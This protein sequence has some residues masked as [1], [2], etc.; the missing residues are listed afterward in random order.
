MARRDQSP[1]G[2]V[3]SRC[4]AAPQA[5]L[6]DPCRLRPRRAGAVLGDA[7]AG[8]AH[9]VLGAPRCRRRI[10][11]GS[12]V[13]AAPGRAGHHRARRFH[14]RPRRRR[15]RG[16]DHDRV[17]RSDLLPA[18]TGAGRSR[19]AIRNPQSA[20][21]DSHHARRSWQH[22]E[23]P[24]PRQRRRRAGAPRLLLQPPCHM[25][26]VLI[27]LGVAVMV[28]SETATLL[29][30]E[31]FWSW[32]TPIAWTGFILFADGVVYRARGDSWIRS[33]PHEFAALALVS[34]PLWLVF[35][36]YNRII[37]NWNYTGLPENFLLRQF[38]YAWS[39][40]TIWPAIFEGADLI[41]VM[42]GSGGPGRS[43]GS[44]ASDRFRTDLRDLPDPPDPLA[45]PALPGPPGLP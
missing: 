32:N 23:G 40:A 41:G 10:I 45:P 39:F 2:R 9:V 14:E 26:A 27:W 22:A 4:G 43:G 34:I 38:G 8:N 19:S 3:G 17:S 6:H 36:G 18:R 44:G 30:I 42:R 12:R 31:P 7:F 11:V 35:E 21:Q 16:D 20:I 25:K 24:D 5:R 13:A 29:R 28:V 1:R 37:D 15:S 33:A